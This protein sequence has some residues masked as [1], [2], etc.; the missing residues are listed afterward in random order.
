[1]HRSSIARLLAPVAIVALAACGKE[2]PKPQEKITPITT[3]TV[4]AMDLPVTETAV[5][6]ETAVGLAQEFDPTRDIAR[7]YYVRLPFPIEIARRLRPGQA[8]TVTNFSDNRSATGYIR[9]IL[10]ALNTL[11]QTTEVIVEVRNPGAWRP[12][13]SVRGEVVL[14]VRR[15]ALVVPE[16]AVVLRPAGSVVYVPEGEIVRERGVTQ[17]IRRNGEVEI[18][19]GLKAGEVVAM[20]GAG[21][22]SEGARI[23]LRD[24]APP[25][26]GGAA[27]NMDPKTAP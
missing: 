2:A 5:G 11:T 27:P 6:A 7:R 25:D 12:A 8:I 9:Q 19:A 23:K 21:L 4:A 10:P 3:Y 24:A 17:G 13:G 16:Q 15:N 22:L 26:R 20:D 18:V 1:M 14:G